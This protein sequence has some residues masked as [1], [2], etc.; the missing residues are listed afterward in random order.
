[1]ARQLDAT[2]GSKLAIFI[3]L[4]TWDGRPGRSPV[5]GDL[6]KPTALPKGLRLSLELDHMAVT[7]GADFLG[8]IL[9]REL[10]PARFSMDPGQPVQA[11]VVRT[12]TQRVVAV[13]SGGIA[14]TGY[15]INLV[16]GESKT[17]AVIGGTARCD[18]GTGSA[19]PAGAYGVMVQISSEGTGRP[20]ST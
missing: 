11:V 5:C 17:V 6:P 14:G 1:L 9:I 7:S 15:P 13:Y 4:T 2:T 18:G 10:G 8:T 12:G 16:R 3:G 19:L 20:R